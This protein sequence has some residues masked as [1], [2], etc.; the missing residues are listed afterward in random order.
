M[1]L[2]ILTQ[3][4][5][6]VEEDKILEALFEEGLDDLH[7]YKP[8]ESPL[9]AE[10]LLTLLSEDYHHKITVHDHFYLK[11]E[12]RLG[13]IHLDEMSQEKPDRYK[14]KV[15]RT[16]TLADDIR[17]AKKKSRYIFLHTGITEPGTPLTASADLYKA[18]RQGLIDKY[19]YAYGGMT[20]DNVSSAH[21][22]GFGGIVI[23]HD[24]WSRFNIHNECDYKDIISYFRKLRSAIE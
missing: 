24:L 15:S 1:K 9:Y 21:D 16:C 8:G 22:L 20:L 4:Q 7:L 18:S 10:R 13:G 12:F 6:F 19:V 14:G 2:V 23:G 11:D 5:Y 3:P 17:Q